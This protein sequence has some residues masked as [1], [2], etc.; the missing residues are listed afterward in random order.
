MSEYAYPELLVTTQWLADHLED[1]DLRVIESDE[2]ITLYYAGHIP[3]AVMVD[4]QSELQDAVIRDY[5]DRQNFERLCGRK[6]IGRDQTLVFYGD[7]NNWW[8][9]Y[10]LWAFQMFGHPRMKILDGGRTKWLDEGRRITREEPNHPATDYRATGPDHTWRAFA[11]EIH[12][13]VEN[14]GQLVDVRSPGEY[15]GELLHMPNYPQEGA[16]RGGHIPG[17]ASC[18]WSR[19]CN[20]DATFKSAD[21]LR[22]IYEGELGLDPGREVIAYCRIGERSSHTWFV[23]H[24]LLGYEKVRNY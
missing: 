5:V 4:W 20:E 6:G 19:A 22:R 11:S 9:C 14:R 3:G 7:N 21:E 1:P 16:L 23:L 13:Y 10:A 8:A 2:D 24:Y 17:A 18:P 12:D 15:T